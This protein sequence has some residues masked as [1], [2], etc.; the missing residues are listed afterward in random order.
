MF[1][2]LHSPHKL[3]L[4]GWKEY[5]LCEVFIQIL[6]SVLICLWYFFFR[7]IWQVWIVNIIVIKV[8][9]VLRVF[10]IL[11][12]LIIC[13]IFFKYYHQMP[14]FSFWHLIF[15]YPHHIIF[16]PMWK[17]CKPRYLVGCSITLLSLHGE[18]LLDTGLFLVHLLEIP[19]GLDTILVHTNHIKAILIFQVCNSSIYIMEF[20]NPAC[21]LVEP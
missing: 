9:Y 14:W 20:C 12:N 8:P 19:R 6:L 4:S 17:P 2:L 18:L 21:I 10:R 13:N 7:V 15:A 11:K 3:G 16:V 5:L 1:A